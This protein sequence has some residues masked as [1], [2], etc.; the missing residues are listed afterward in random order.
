MDR[1]DDRQEARRGAV[2]VA[3][4]GDIDGFS[5]DR[6]ESMCT[7]YVAGEKTWNKWN[8]WPWAKADDKE[9]ILAIY[10][11]GGVF[12]RPGATLY[13]SGGSQLSVCEGARL[14]V[15]GDFL[16]WDHS[17]VFV[18]SGADLVLGAE[19]SETYGCMNGSVFV[20][21][22]RRVELSDAIIGPGCWISDGD[23]HDILDQDGNLLNP[24]APVKFN[25]HVWLGQDV[26][27]LK[28]VEIGS[29]SV[30]GAKSLVCG[31]VPARSVV[32]GNPAKVVKTGITWLHEFTR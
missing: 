3:S 18:Q 10:G 25:R 26:T 9:S 24:V 1:T 31:N 30:V 2:S 13:L 4:T 19:G 21:V 22:A 23:W 29:G 8:E 12:V 28:G 7:G 16:L 6:L 14:F 15:L 27:V 5:R 20:N 11:G 32:V 17:K